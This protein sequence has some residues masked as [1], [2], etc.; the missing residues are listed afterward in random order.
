[1]VMTFVMSGF[2]DREDLDLKTRILYT[3]AAL[4]VLGRQT[5][6]VVYVDRATGATTEE[7]REAIL[8]MAEFWGFQAIWDPLLTMKVCLDI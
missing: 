7:I 3:I 5:Q 4:T 6:R 1:M 2:Y 8:Q